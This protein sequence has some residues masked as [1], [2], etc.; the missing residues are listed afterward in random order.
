V[1]ARHLILLVSALGALTLAACGEAVDDVPA[2]NAEPAAAA[3]PAHGSPW[4]PTPAPAAFPAHGSPW[5]PTPA[6][7]GTEDPCVTR[8]G[9]RC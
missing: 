7:A 9:P 3:F 1:P 2:A 5:Y 6:P 4:Y 8:L